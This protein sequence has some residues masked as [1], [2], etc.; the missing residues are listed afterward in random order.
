MIPLVENDEIMN[1]VTLQSNAGADTAEA[2]P[3]DD[4]LVVGV[5][6]LGDRLRSTSMPCSSDVVDEFTVG[7]EQISLPTFQELTGFDLVGMETWSQVLVQFR[8]S[9]PRT[10]GP[11]NTARFAG[12]P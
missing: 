4:D 2:R 8:A 6:P 12:A 1:S 11:R 3:D 5:D 10:K 9:I 7:P